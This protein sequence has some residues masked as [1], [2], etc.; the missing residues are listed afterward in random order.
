MRW[1]IYNNFA[2]HDAYILDHVKA[3]DLTKITIVVTQN[4]SKVGSSQK[5]KS[6]ALKFF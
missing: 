3:E 1:L 2:S 5:V 6:V 4:Q